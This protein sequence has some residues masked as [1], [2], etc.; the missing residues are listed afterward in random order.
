M[1]TQSKYSEY[2]QG[3]N[4]Q[5]VKAIEQ[6]RTTGKSE[7]INLEGLSDLGKRDAAGWNATSYVF[8]D[9]SITKNGMT[10]GKQAAEVLKA[11]L[12]AD[13]G[14]DDAYKVTISKTCE[15]TITRVHG[16]APKVEEPTAEPVE[17]TT[18]ISSSESSEDIQAMENAIDVAA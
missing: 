2:F 5:F 13:G 4:A 14:V 18:G 10:H 6:A 15:L 16:A 1:A 7:P 12:I 3:L 9:G 17:D 11:V 8:A